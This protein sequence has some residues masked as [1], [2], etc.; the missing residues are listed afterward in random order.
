V[1]K[2]TEKEKKRIWPRRQSGLL[3]KMCAFGPSSFHQFSTE[4]ERGAK[5]NWNVPALVSSS[6]HLRSIFFFFLLFRFFPPSSLFFF[7]LSFIDS[8]APSC[9][10][11]S[12][13]ISRPFFYRFI[14][15]QQNEQTNVERKD[16]RAKR[17]EL[18]L[19][20][21]KRGGGPAKKYIYKI[22]LKNRKRK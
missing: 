14:F 19:S 11:S 1:D 17:V 15:Q 4:R 5:W 7:D 10:P 21:R 6:L 16:L 22:N 18:F 20:V 2:E 3:R 13:S 8:L 9:L 12:R